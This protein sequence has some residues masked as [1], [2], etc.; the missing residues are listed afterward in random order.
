MKKSADGKPEFVPAMEEA[1]EK[2]V[3]TGNLN[4]WANFLQCVRTREKPVRDIEVC[5]RSTTTCLLGNVALR[6]K[7]KL[8]WDA[9]KWTTQQADA[10]KFLSREYRTPWKLV[11]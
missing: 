9:E 7:L 4:H 8:D 2:P 3:D 11:V 5:Q 10:R 1:E 6:S